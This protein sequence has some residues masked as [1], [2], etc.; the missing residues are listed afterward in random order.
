MIDEISAAVLFLT[1]LIGKNENLNPLQIE[2]FKTR[3]SNLLVQ[4]FQNHWFPEKP[5]KGQGYRCIRVN[6][7]DRRDPVLERAAQECG[8]RYEDLQL[9]V[10]LTVWV[11][12]TEVCCRF[13]EHKG[14][15]C[16]VASFKEGNKENNMDHLNVD[17]IE[18]NVNPR[19]KQ[20]A[21]MPKKNLPPRNKNYFN[22]T[23]RASLHNPIS[24]PKQHHYY[25]HRAPLHQQ[26]SYAHYG[27]PSPP[28]YV[29]FPIHAKGLVS[30]SST[31]PSTAISSTI[32]P[33][34]SPPYGKT[35][36]NSRGRYPQQQQQQH[37]HHHNHRQVP[38]FALS[39]SLTTIPT[40]STAQHHIPARYDHYQ[41][42]KKSTIKA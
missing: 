40:S 3:L 27:P 2:E 22:S 30:T 29:F 26:N 32:P 13:G 12:P 8:L 1:R 42:I 19:S 18:P 39:G 36:S 15:Y 5:F 11:D 41:W 28:N 4:R 21:R 34:T 38:H 23:S 9:P 7:M 20:D 17:E 16:T 10:E 33:P 37:H 31:L 35:N 25:T 6:E 24:P 14:S